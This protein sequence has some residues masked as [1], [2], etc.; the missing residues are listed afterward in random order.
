MAV[1]ER[2]NKMRDGNELQ[3][4]QEGGGVSKTVAERE[5]RGHAGEFRAASKLCRRNMFAAL[6]MGNIPNVDVLCSSSNANAAIC[7]QVKTFR[8]HEKTCIVGENAE[9]DYGENFMW[10][11][12]GLRDEEHDSCEES[13]Y[14]IPSDVMATNVT[15]L[16]KKWESIPRKDGKPHDNNGVRKVRIGSIG[17]SD[18]LMFDVSA[19]RDRWDLIEAAV[20][21]VSESK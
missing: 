1:G 18:R 17:K 9:I 19:Y 11:L 13:F 21:K 12:A 7:I 6:T 3:S 10:I 8:A 20:R 2:I 4:N 15:K 5:A 14:I 16:H